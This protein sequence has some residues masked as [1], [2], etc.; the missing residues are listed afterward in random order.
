[1]IHSIPLNLIN[2]RIRK[3]H[4]FTH[5]IAK[6]GT[7]IK[8]TGFVLSDFCPTFYPLKIYKELVTSSL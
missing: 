6:M 1:M 2:V 4:F 8:I 3:N 5:F 7:I